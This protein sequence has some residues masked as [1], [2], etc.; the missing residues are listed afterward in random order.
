MIDAPIL[1]WIL[2]MSWSQTGPDGVKH[3][4]GQG[5]VIKAKNVDEALDQAKTQF[6]ELDKIREQTMNYKN[7]RA[8]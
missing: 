5:I 1:E 2:E 7:G 3:K 8:I 4:L 6:G